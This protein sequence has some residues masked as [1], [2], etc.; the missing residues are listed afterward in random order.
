MNGN[1]E[2]VFSNG[3]KEEKIETIATEEFQVSEYEATKAEEH[4]KVEEGS[5]P[6]Y[7]NSL[8]DPSFFTEQ[9]GTRIE[10]KDG[11]LK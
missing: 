9:Q 5:V 2:L 1:V 6:V 11:G 7:A 10:M 8:L 4:P 3:L